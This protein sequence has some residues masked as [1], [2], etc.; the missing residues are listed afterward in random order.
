MIEI[1]FGN[2][3]VPVRILVENID[4]LWII[5][6]IVHKT[7]LGFAAVGVLNAIFV[8]ETFK[9]AAL[10]D[11]LMVRQTKIKQGH[12]SK[13][14]RALFEEAD[15]DGNGTLDMDEWIAVCQDDWVQTW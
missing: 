7:I 2:F 12:H 14:M 11:N 9:A 6:A 4:E 8:Q 1:T 15:T 3:V 13:K 5:Y 10:D